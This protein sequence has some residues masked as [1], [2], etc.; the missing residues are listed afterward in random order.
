MLVYVSS[1]PC[2]LVVAGHGALLHKVAE[3]ERPQF[4]IHSG[5]SNV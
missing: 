1:L 3:S 2:L 5:M 4:G